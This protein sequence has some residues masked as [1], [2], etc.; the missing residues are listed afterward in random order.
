MF[1]KNHLKTVLFYAGALLVGIILGPFIAGLI[2]AR[3][4]TPAALAE[5]APVAALEPDSPQAVYVCTPAYI[6]AF[7][8]R[9][10]VRCTVAAPGG[11]IYFAAPTS[12]SKNAARILSIMLTAKA[13][14][15]NLQVYYT[16]SASGASFGCQTG[17]CRPIDAIEMTP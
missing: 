8:T 15:K 5:A 3:Q 2:P 12:D 7:K 11:I 13:L 10:H 1:L 4:P 17:D 16:A 9:V 14:G 6:G